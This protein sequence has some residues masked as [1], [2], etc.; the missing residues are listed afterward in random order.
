MRFH[1]ACSGALMTNV[2]A[3][4]PSVDQLLAH[5]EI[6]ALVTQYGHTATVAVIRAVLAEKRSQ[7]KQHPETSTDIAMLVADCRERMQQA[8]R[9]S[10]APVYNLTGTV[11]H[12]N[13]GRA[14]LSH[15]AA[16]AV[17][18]VME[19]PCNLEFDVDSA[20]RGDRDDHIDSLICELTGAEAATVVNNN[21]AAVFL[22][23]N[24]LAM[25]KQVI[26][27][28]GELIEIGG[29]FRIP[30][31][32]ARAGAKLVEVGTTNRTHLKDYAEAIT[33]RT[34]LLMKVH[35]S[36][37]AIQGFT[38]SVPEEE[39]SQLAREHGLPFV[40]DLGSGTLVDFS[41]YGLPKEHTV[42]EA[43]AQG[44]DLVTFSGDKLLGGPQAGIIVGKKALIEKLKRNPLKRA[45]RVD[46]MTMAAL[47]ATLRH[48][49]HPELLTRDIPTLR[50][51]TRS[52]SDIEAVAQSLLPHVQR[53]LSSHAHAEVQPCHSQ[54]GS[55]SLPVDLLPSFCIAISP[56]QQGRG[57]GSQLNRTAQAFRTLPQPVIGRIEDGQLRFD[58]RL[59]EDPHAFI[60]QLSA[61]QL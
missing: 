50:T 37:Y 32:M 8:A 54:I 39:V 60:Q 22:L 33:P 35:P 34:G 23:L 20:K 28:R 9:P 58:L 48:Y 59:L 56:T 45:L 24:T 31:I 25:R 18:A 44:A 57:A 26:V 16:Q 19:T 40:I 55:G 29:A 17:Q 12:T 52:P 42:Q 11:L 46:K 21:A 13:L 49:R 2:F 47:E 53:A 43:I 4:L 7:L 41:A 6:Q 3:A 61:L 30:D 1:P 51:L 5:A 27:S 36:N 15:Q 38:K 14:L 10:L